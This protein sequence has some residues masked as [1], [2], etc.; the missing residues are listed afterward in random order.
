MAETNNSTAKTPTTDDL[1]AA[2]NKAN[3]GFY[4][5]NALALAARALVELSDWDK[6]ERLTSVFVVLRTI[7]D[8]AL[9]FAS[10]ADASAL[11]ISSG[12]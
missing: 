2:L 1:K 10:D 11:G 7:S 12:N 8:K 9:E 5:L 4:D 6:C 3:L